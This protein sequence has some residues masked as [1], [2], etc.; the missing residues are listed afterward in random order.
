MSVFPAP[1]CEC[2]GALPFVNLRSVAAVRDLG[3]PVGPEA[4]SGWD[5]LEA[6]GFIAPDDDGNGESPGA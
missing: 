5:V 3:E 2:A 4:E 1:G 6:F